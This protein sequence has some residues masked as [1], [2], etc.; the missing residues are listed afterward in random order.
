[1]IDISVLYLFFG[2]IYD[3]WQITYY[4]LDSWILLDDKYYYF[5]AGP[6]NYDNAVASCI[7]KGGKL[8]EPKNEKVNIEVT[9]LAKDRGFDYF[10]LGINDKSQENNFVY[11][12]DGSP[13]IYENWCDPDCC[14]SSSGKPSGNGD[15]VWIGWI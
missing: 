7:N 4:F 12:N 2:K 5:N 10:W 3:Y 11:A 6:A 1:M 13:I 15:C 8:F 14:L 9:K